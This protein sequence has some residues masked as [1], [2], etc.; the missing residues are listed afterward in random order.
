MNNIKSNEFSEDSLNLQVLLKDIIKILKRSWWVIIAAFVCLTA[1]YCGYQKYTYVPTYEAKASFTVN[2][3][4]SYA[5]IA[6]SYGFYYD[7]ANA[8]QMAKVLPYIL[9]SSVFN[10]ILKEE[11]GTDKINGTISLSAIKNSNLFSVSVVSKDPQ[12]AKNILDAVVKKLPDVSRYVIG[13]TKLNIIQPSSVPTKPNNRNNY[14]LSALICLVATLGISAIVITITAFLRKTIQTEQDFRDQLNMNCIGIL[15]YYKLDKKNSSKPLN[16]DETTENG[17]RYAECMKAIALKV[18]RSMQK[19]DSKVLMVTAALVNEGKTSV[20][21]NLARYIKAGNPDKK[22]ALVDLDFR[23]LSLSKTLSGNAGFYTVNSFLPDAK[24]SGRHYGSKKSSTKSKNSIDEMLNAFNEKPNDVIVFGSKEPIK[25]PETILNSDETR[26]LISRIREAADYVIV[27][28]PP[29]AITTDPLLISEY[30]DSILFVIR[31]DS[32]HR[33]TI[34]D[35]IN[36]ISTR[37][38]NII[39]GVLNAAKESILDPG[40]SYNYYG[41]GRYGRY[42]K[43]GY[44][45]YGNYGYGKFGYGKYGYDED[46]T[47]K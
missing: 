18:T 35:C 6:A 39:G 1:I 25:S 27:D 23:K 11:L 19:T 3:T 7:S 2:T 20:A 9:K 38:C 28:S 34:L 26:E 4:S 46:S 32:T 5:E 31:Q 15:P 14:I 30:C 21:L 29:C 45:S 12:D 37:G 22:V 44:R 41:Y 16:T 33:W 13:E 43:Y 17:K 42:G 47:E 10:E 40:Y 24:S 8:E 36:N